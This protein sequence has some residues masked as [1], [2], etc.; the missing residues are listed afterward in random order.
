[1]RLLCVKSLEVKEF[2]PNEVPRY[3]ILSHRWLSN[4]GEVTLQ[5]M[6]RNNAIT[7]PGYEKLVKSCK[8]AKEDGFDYV[9]IDTSCIDKTSSAELSESINSMFRWYKNAAVCYAFLADVPSDSALDED[10]P[11]A[12]RAGRT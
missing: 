9:W 3:A 6:E 8:Q 5:D 4:D 7:K 1:M 11:F 12:K 2:A 10:S